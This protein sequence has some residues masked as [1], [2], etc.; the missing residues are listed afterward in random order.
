MAQLVGIFRAS[1]LGDLGETTNE[2]KLVLMNH[3]MSTG[4]LVSRLNGRVVE[5]TAA[6]TVG[7]RPVEDRQ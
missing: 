4:H 6:E 1:F 5:G 3:V 2:L 7:R